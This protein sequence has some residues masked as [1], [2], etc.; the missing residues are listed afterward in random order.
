MR[1]FATLTHP[2]EVAAANGWM[3]A[4]SGILYFG[5]GAAVTA[6]C[7]DPTPLEPATCAAGI[8]AAGVT[9]T[10]AAGALATGVY[11]F[12]NVTLPAFK[13]WGCPEWNSEQV[14]VVMTDSRPNILKWMLLFPSTYAIFDVAF[15]GLVGLSL[16]LSIQKLLEPFALIFFCGV[17]ASVLTYWARN[18]YRQPRSGA[19]R[20]SLGFFVYL[21]LFMS[22][23]LFSAA[24]N[25]IIANAS[26]LPDFISIVC[27]GSIIAAVVV[28]F[29]ARSRLKSCPK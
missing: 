15:V 1:G 24:K 19:V 3:F 9:A 18:S 26:L 7:G 29:S 4:T 12:K 21:G 6:G 23:L 5:V 10:A 2:L 13:E 14:T 22:V 16:R 8:G 11:F 20:L 28:Y 25:G 27:P 17:L